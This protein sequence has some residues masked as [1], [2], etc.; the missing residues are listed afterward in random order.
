MYI[1]VI[2]QVLV[3]SDYKLVRKYPVTVEKLDLLNVWQPYLTVKNIPTFAKE[4]SVR[5]HFKAAANGAELQSIDLKEGEAT[6]FYE[7]AKGM[8]AVIVPLPHIMYD[9]PSFLVMQLP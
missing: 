7:D 5:R 9:Q 6:I 3:K 1:V 4:D 8:P 2:P